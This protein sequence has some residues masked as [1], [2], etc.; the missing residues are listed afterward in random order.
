MLISLDAQCTAVRELDG[1]E[2][3]G[4]PACTTQNVAYVIYTSGSTGQPKG[5]LVEHRQAVNLAH[6]TIRNVGLTAADRV[7][8]FASLSFDVSVKDIFTA[9]AGRR[10]GGARP[11]RKRDCRR[12]RWPR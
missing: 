4:H 9:A 1:S 2:P 5:V 8:Q 10:P 3:A 6:A 12:G 7:L 11:G